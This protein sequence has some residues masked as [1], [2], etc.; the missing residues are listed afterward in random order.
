[1]RPTGPFAGI[2]MSL[3]SDLYKGIVGN[4]TKQRNGKER[5]GKEATPSLLI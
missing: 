5:K 1:M 2:Y 4:R 3:E